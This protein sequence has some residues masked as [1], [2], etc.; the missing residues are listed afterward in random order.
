MPDDS[1]LGKALHTLVGY[2]DQPTVMQLVVYVAILA[3]TFGLMRIFAA[4]ARP[5]AA[6]PA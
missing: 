4:P 3:V 6:Q 1:I 2:T 5:A